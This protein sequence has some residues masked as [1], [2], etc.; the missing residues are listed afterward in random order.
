MN[1]S[2]RKLLILIQKS[3][4]KSKCWAKE[5]PAVSDAELIPLEG[6]P[7]LIP[8][9]L[10]KLFLKRKKVDG[11]VFRYLNDYP[12]LSRTLAR[13]FTEVLSYYLMLLLHRG[14]VAWI[15]HN[16]NNESEVNFPSISRLRRRFLVTRSIK[17]F[18]TSDLLVRHATKYLGVSQSKI[19]VASFGRPP[20]ISAGVTTQGILSLREVV[21]NARFQFQ[22]VGLWIGSPAE[23]SAD[24]LKSFL[25][26][27]FRAQIN[28]KQ[29]FGVIIGV[30]E[31]W[32]EKSVGR[33]L[34]VNIKAMGCIEVI[35]PLALPWAEWQVFDY[36]WK[37]CDDVS[38]TMTV[39]NAAAAGVP[40]VVHTES[41]ISEFIQCYRL[42]YSVHP[43]CPQIDWTVLSHH[44]AELKEVLWSHQSWK[45]GAAALAAAFS[46]QE[47]N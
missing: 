10:I 15:C 19:A 4:L 13:L 5:I 42:G 12:S 23:K 3:D 20:N 14:R 21:K 11:L 45:R 32:I 1:K 37:P 7:L 38:L 29:H 43:D 24:G 36:I 33:E 18:V 46:R 41:F 47:D 40:M 2:K 16:V 27:I 22:M 6:S 9:S 35:G 30:T 39:L 44:P 31:D 26:Y 17:I 28:K 8:A 25:K 34:Y